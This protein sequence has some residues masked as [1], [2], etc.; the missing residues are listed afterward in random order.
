LAQKF[1][2]YVSRLRIKE[3]KKVQE[4]NWKETSPKKLKKKQDSQKTKK[5]WYLQ[6]HKIEKPF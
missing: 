5:R 1:P 2:G 6:K 4:Q 3:K